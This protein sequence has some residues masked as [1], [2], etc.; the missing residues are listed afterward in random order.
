GET[1]LFSADFRIRR[2]LDVSPDRR[3]LLVLSSDEPVQTESPLMLLPLP[4]GTPHRLG[5]VLAHDASWSRDGKSIAYAN[6]RDLYVAQ[7]DGS[8]PRKLAMLAGNV[9]WPR[10]SHDGS[11]IRFTILDALGRPALWEVSTD[12]SR[13]HPMLSTRDK[14]FGE[15]CGNWTAD[16][17]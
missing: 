4:S 11:V 10:W 6:G 1:A 14:L 13:L 17:R 12:S 16:G 2:V 3:E 5:D 7:A 9:W 8:E 15:C